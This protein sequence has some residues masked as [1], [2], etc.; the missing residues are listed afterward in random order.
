MGK[1]IILGTMMAGVLCREDFFYSECPLSESLILPILA[2][3][4]ISRSS[5]ISEADLQSP[6]KP[7]L[8]VSCIRASIPPQLSHFKNSLVI[9]DVT[10]L[11]A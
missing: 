6:S 2:N 4:T 1:L 7:F 10:T 8:E 3:S 11:L 9:N 5:T